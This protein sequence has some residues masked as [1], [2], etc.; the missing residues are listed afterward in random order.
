MEGEAPEVRA[1]DRVIATGWTARRQGPMNPGDSGAGR[2]GLPAGALGSLHAPSAD[3]VEPLVADDALA[4]RARRAWLRWR[5]DARA[6]LARAMNVEDAGGPG[7]MLAAI[8]L[9][10]R[11]YD[12]P[13]EQAIR[14]VGLAHLMAMSGLH[15]AILIAGAAVPLRLAGDL[16]RWDAVILTVVIVLALAI[17]P[18]EAVIRTV[19]ILLAL[20]IIP[21][22]APIVRAAVMALAL[23][24]GRAMGRRWDSVAVLAWTAVGVLI[25]RP[26]EL[27]SMGFQLSFGLVLALITLGPVMQRRLFG[28]RVVGGLERPPSGWRWVVRG[29]VESLKG[30]VGASVLCW[31]VALP[32][33]LFHT[34]MLSPLAIPATVVTLPLIAVTLLAA[35]LLAIIALLFPAAQDA[36]GAALQWLASAA[37]DLVVT[38]DT[39]PWASFDLPRLSL[40]WTIA[41]TLVTIYIVL[42]A[43]WRDG[44]TWALVGAT[45]AWLGLEIQR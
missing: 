16:G 32:L 10:Q 25:W 15:L 8:A 33:T 22:R 19:V 9:G 39:A 26:A 29:G 5:A 12:A 24:G 36:A 17:I 23:L 7:A 42:R 38:I 35:Y 31:L 27:W 6:A 40:V 37:H 43:R 1:G 18:A 2:L 13:A 30:L 44:L 41:A 28:R 4:Q 34:G 21:A 11:D 3:L 20:A 14:R 45:L